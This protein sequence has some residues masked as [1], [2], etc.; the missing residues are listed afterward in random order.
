MRSPNPLD[1]QQQRH[2]SPAMSVRS[3]LS[4]T[5]SPARP[6]EEIAAPEEE[7]VLK[8]G[9]LSVSSGKKK[10]RFERR[11]FLLKKGAEI[12]YHMKTPKVLISPFLSFT[13]QYHSL[14]NVARLGLQPRSS[15]TLGARAGVRGEHEGTEKYLPDRVT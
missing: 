14:D 11:Y 1:D 5:N 2:Y 4:M 15:S 10:S 12:L 6:E 13:D 7:Q 8:E 9:W 3:V